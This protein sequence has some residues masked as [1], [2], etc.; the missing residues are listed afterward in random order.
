MIYTTQRLWKWL[1]TKYDLKLTYIFVIKVNTYGCVASFY[2]EI[3]SVDIYIIMKLI[4]NQQETLFHRVIILSSLPFL[5]LFYFPYQ[6]I[7]CRLSK[8]Y[9]F[10]FSSLAVKP[11]AGKYAVSIMSTCYTTGFIRP[12]LAIRVSALG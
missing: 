1:K 9:F 7:T 4:Q 10:L 6:F 3:L 2:H 5:F 12:F 11:K 8:L